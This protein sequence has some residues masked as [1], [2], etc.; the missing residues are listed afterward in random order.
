M[1]PHKMAVEM[2]LSLGYRVYIL[3]EKGA[4][5]NVT[6]DRLDTYLESQGIDSDNIV[7][8]KVD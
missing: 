8:K 4:L 6:I 3:K 7:L 1:M 2:L 5:E